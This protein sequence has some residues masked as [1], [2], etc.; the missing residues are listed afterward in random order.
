MT[1][2]RFC[3]LISAIYCSAALIQI[4]TDV[5]TGGAFLLAIGWMWTATLNRKE[6]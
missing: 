4:D 1:S 6:K 5:S 2:Q 3:I